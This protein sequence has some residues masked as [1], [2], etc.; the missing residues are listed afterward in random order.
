MNERS[1]PN[2]KSGSVRYVLTAAILFALAL[3]QCST[4][5]EEVPKEYQLKAV[6]LFRLAQFTDW[7]SEAFADSESPLVIGILGGNPFGPAL[8]IATKGE[9]AHGRPI[10]V[11][12]FRTPDDASGCHMLY[13]ART[14]AGRVRKILNE[15]EKKSVLTVSDIE[16]FARIGGMVRFLPEDNKVGLRVNL[17]AV[18]TAGLTIDARLLRMAQILKK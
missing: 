1:D 17:E 18:K 3:L 13:I 8:E 4:N 7:P 16:D 14:E 9:T 2:F 6:L 5:C 15:Y 11:K 10:K 12:Y